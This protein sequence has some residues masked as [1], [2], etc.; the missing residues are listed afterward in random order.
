MRAMRDLERE[1]EPDDDLPM[2]V[3][4][5]A[6][7]D[8]REA[9]SYWLAS[10]CVPVFSTT[11]GYEANVVLKAMEGGLLVTDRALPPWP[12]LDPIKRLLAANPRL[13]IAYVDDGG[14]GDV[15]AQLTGAHVILRKPLDVRHVLG[16]LGWPEPVS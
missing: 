8:V 13:R 9:I 12:G 11:D 5:C 4:L 1:S 15:L 16:A 6:D 10:T 14:E 2:V 3:L 7:R